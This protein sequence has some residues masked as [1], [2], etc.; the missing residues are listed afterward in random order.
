MTENELREIYKRA[1]CDPEPYVTQW[2]IAEQYKHDYYN[3]LHV[4]CPVCGHDK[5]SSTYVGY[6]IDMLKPQSYVDGNRVKCQCGWSGVCHDLVP[7]N[8]SVL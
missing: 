6:L 1:G 3:V 5:H 2:K 8:K 4:C 7:R